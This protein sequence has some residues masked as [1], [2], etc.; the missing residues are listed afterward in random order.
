MK[1]KLV[2]I[3]VIVPVYNTQKYIT[4]CLESIL[5]QSLEEIEI[6]VVN[7][8]SS[9]QSLQIIDGYKQNDQRIHV[10]NHVKNRGLPAARNS[11]VYHAKGQY[12]IHL[13]SDDFWIDRDMLKNLFERSEIDGCDILRFNGYRFNKSLGEKKLYNIELTNSAF[14]NEKRLWIYGAVYLYFFRKKFL[15]KNKLKFHEGISIGEDAIFLS[16]ALPE[17]K[18]ISSITNKYYAY[19]EN[20]ESLMRKVWSLDEFLQEERSAQIVIENL[21]MKSDASLTFLI[22]RIN[23]YWLIKIAPRAFEQLKPKD[24]ITF[25][26]SASKNFQILDSN[27][28][29]IAKKLSK[30]AM[31]VQKYFQKKEYK[32]LERDFRSR[33]NNKLSSMSKAPFKEWPKAA[34]KH[35]NYED[36]VGYKIPGKIFIHAGT[37]KSGSSLL[38]V[39]LDENRDA[40]A[41]RGYF[42]SSSANLLR[43]GINAHLLPLSLIDKVNILNLPVLEADIIWSNLLQE[44]LDSGCK[45][46]IISS[47]FFCPEVTW[48]ELPD[49]SLLKKFIGNNDVEF[50]FYLREQAERLESGYSQLIRSAPRYYSKT[51]KEY[52]EDSKD[53]ADYKKLL[54]IYAEQFGLS[55]INPRLYKHSTLTKENICND[56]LSILGIKDS[57]TFQAV[58]KKVN[59]RWPLPVTLFIQQAQSKY[60]DVFSVEEQNDFNHFIKKQYLTQTML[61][62]KISYCLLSDKERGEIAKYFAKSNLAVSKQYFNSTKNLFVDEHIKL[63]KNTDSNPSSSFKF[64]EGVLFNLLAA[65]WKESEAKSTEINQLKITKK[66]N[67]ITLLKFIKKAIR[68]MIS[69]KNPSK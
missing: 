28:D 46:L 40:L 68:A 62:P 45:H 67:L 14:D 21:G 51:F 52:L 7:D 31:E 33:I 32:S 43:T 3:S 47:E 16:K 35:K 53:I 10:I 44:Y 18:G 39:F 64:E 1:N 13:D 8:C 19:R 22:D 58:N 11:G 48:D 30:N 27:T 36:R 65:T 66:G 6:I 55:S 38:Q 9:D 25:F 60:G 69:V 41:R 24:R 59:E 2:K 26:E 20:N 56:F 29:K 57:D 15:D 4:Q 61:E 5:I 42:Y 34:I 54:D 23:N 37:H 12:I 50:I 49:L 17:A 63:Q